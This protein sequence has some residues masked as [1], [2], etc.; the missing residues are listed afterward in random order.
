M[1]A[2]NEMPRSVPRRTTSGA[3]RAVGAVATGALPVAGD[4]TSVAG[5]AG[6]GALG[7][8]ASARPS[9]PP[10]AKRTKSRRVGRG[11]E[12]RAGWPFTTSSPLAAALHPQQRVNAQLGA[13][14]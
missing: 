11:A 4:P 1:T 7:L 10:P 2:P 13:R 14:P 5:L 3:R 12:R 6:A 9:V 8:Q